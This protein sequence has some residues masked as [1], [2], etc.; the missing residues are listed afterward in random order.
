MNDTALTATA[1]TSDYDPVAPDPQ[2]RQILRA[3]TAG[4]GAIGVGFAAVPFIESW[5]PSEQARALGAPVQIDI[6]A[7]APGTMMTVVWRQKP[8]WV[9][10]RLESQLLELPTLNAR[11]KDPLSQEPQQAPNLPDW[12]PIQRSIR[13]EYLVLVGICTHLGCIPKYRPRSDAGNLGADWPG[14]F[15]CPCHGSRYDLAGRV[16]DGSPA[17]LNLPVPPYYFRSPT[18]IVAGDLESGAESDWQPDVW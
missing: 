2:R 4:L 5:E 17:P 8:V 14:G 7:L 18:L 9:L 16:M 6:S 10:R 13:P 1:Q 15:Y 3:A 12:N 11:L